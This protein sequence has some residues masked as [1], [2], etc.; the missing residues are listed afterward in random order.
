MRD[1]RVP[2]RGDAVGGAVSRIVAGAGV[3]AVVLAGTIYWE[4]QESARPDIATVTSGRSPLIGTVRA[5]PGL[6][7]LD[8]VQGWVSTALGRPLFREDRRPA[9]TANDV[10]QK[11][12]A[13]ARLTGV[14][15]GPFGNRAIFMSGENQPPIVAKEGA[16]VSDFVVRSIQPDQVIVE[17]DGNVR[18]LKPSFAGPANAPRR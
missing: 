15:T 2:V 18:T 1:I 4:V 16:R 7:S 3:A 5:A 10:A 11:G 17:T 13:P 9:K 6:A 8:V 14:I 12:D